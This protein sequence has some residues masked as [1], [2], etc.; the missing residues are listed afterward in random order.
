MTYI[1]DTIDLYL[2]QRGSTDFKCFVPEKLA[3]AKSTLYN[4]ASSYLDPSR[5]DIH[6]KRHI[7][8]QY[9][10]IGRSSLFM[11]Q[12]LYLPKLIGMNNL[13]TKS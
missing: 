2:S 9:L 4:W 1:C 7:I 11:I 12:I 5:R 13:S 6:M 8:N 10:V 3:I